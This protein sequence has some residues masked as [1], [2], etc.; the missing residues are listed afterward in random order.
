MKKISVVVADKYPL[1]LKGIVTFLSN[2]PSRY[3]VSSTFTDALSAAEYCSQYQPDIFIL[4]EFSDGL[5]GIELI[6]W[7]HSMRITSKLISYMEKKPYIDATKFINAG[8]MG[9]VWK[10]SPPENLKRAIEHIY[11][12]SNYFDDGLLQQSSVIR[13]PVPSNFLTGRERQILQLIA[14]G[15]TNKHIAK[16]LDVSN[17]TVET[18]RLNLMKKMDVHSGIELLKVGLRMGVCTI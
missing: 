1:M 12:N 18:H 10:N 7:V 16:I 6:R 3:E 4:G 9:V 14:D 11:N 13:K 2:D 8:A 5:G 17:K 15:Q